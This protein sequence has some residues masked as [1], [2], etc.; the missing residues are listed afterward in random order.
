MSHQQSDKHGPAIDDALQDE[1]HQ[2]PAGTRHKDRP[3]EPD[4][5]F[6]DDAVDDPPQD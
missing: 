3:D 5:A 6:E 1:R 2:S 4:S